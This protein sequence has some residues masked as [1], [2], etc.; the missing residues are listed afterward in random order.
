[1]FFQWKASDENV[2]VVAMWVPLVLQITSGCVHDFAD[3]LKKQKEVDG[4]WKRKR[5]ELLPRLLCKRGYQID[6]FGFNRALQTLK[7]A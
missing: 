4:Y 2:P 1:L 5:L 6:S 7:S 3:D